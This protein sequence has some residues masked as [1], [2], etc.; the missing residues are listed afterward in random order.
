[1]KRF[2]H[3]GDIYRNDVRLDFSANINPFGMPA[4]VRAAII[5]NA[6]RLS[7]YPDAECALLR[8]KIA[9]REGVQTE[10]ILCGNGAADLIFSIVRAVNPRRALLIA[11]TFSEYEKA[12]LS[13]G[14]EIKFFVLSEGNGVELTESFL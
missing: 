2:E 7:V 4:G 1:M 14:C 11:P 8:A 6:D 9:E 13:V 10:N 12:L 5:E 3:G